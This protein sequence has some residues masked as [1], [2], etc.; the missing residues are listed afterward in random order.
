MKYT[1]ADI[2]RLEGALSGAQLRG[3]RE[4]KAKL[5]EKLLR[6]MDKLGVPPHLVKSGVTQ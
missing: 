1:K 3:I 2:D 5:F 6:K 4:R